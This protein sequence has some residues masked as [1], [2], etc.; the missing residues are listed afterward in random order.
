MK[1]DFGKVFATLFEGSMAGTGA[2]NFAT[3][4][5]AITRA[6]PWQQ[7]NEKLVAHLNEVVMAAAIGETVEKVQASIEYLCSPDPRS[8]TKDEDGRR[9]VKVEEFTYWVVNGR[10]YREMGRTDLRE[11]WRKQKQRQRQRKKGKRAP[12]GREQRYLQAETDEERDRI[13]AEGLPDNGAPGNTDT[14]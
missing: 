6:E 14:P 11:R 13:A 9:L 7:D 4:V 5:Y 12:S 2:L 8:T 10:K 1:Y 3:W